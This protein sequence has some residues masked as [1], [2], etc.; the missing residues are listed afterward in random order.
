MNLTSIHEDA[1][2]IPG[3]AQWVKDPALPCTVV[4]GCRHGSD[5]A[6]LWLW[7]RPATTADSTSS[8]GT[9]YAAGAALKRQK[10]KKKKKV[11]AASWGLCGLWCWL[12]YNPQARRAASEVLQRGTMLR[13]LIKGNN[14]VPSVRGE[15]CSALAPFWR[16][17][18][19]GREPWGGH[20]RSFFANRNW[21]L[22]GHNEKFLLTCP[23]KIQK[24][25]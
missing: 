18:P 4:Q 23:P 3:R 22:P 9:S 8:L 6:L 20:F 24:R 14:V 21:P 16:M 17:K 7:C 2:S 11:A 5:L 15:E 12:G 1:G 25:G 10:K 19:G 13:G